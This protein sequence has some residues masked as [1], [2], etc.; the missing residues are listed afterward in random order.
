[1]GF[2]NNALDEFK[3]LGEKRRESKQ[4][5]IKKF[6]VNSEKFL[7]IKRGVYNIAFQKVNEAIKS[8]PALNKQEKAE[9]W[10]DSF[11]N[12]KNLELYTI[13]DTPKEKLENTNIAREDEKKLEKK[14]NSPEKPAGL[15]SP[16]SSPLSPSLFLSDFDSSVDDSKTPTPIPQDFPGFENPTIIKGRGKWLEAFKESNFKEV[17][18]SITD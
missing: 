6:E 2:K 8:N 17:A 5:N 14:R 1:M 12:N 9:I 18:I 4:R 15:D 13:K 11:N 16:N 7:E 3:A 10:L